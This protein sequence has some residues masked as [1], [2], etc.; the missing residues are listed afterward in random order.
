[1]LVHTKRKNNN[2][3]YLCVAYLHILKNEN[4]L[5]KSTSGK[6]WMTVF[7]IHILNEAQFKA[8]YLLCID[9]KKSFRLKINDYFRFIS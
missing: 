2:F 9:Q 5:M 8:K 4:N 6:S 7:D 3:P 1:M